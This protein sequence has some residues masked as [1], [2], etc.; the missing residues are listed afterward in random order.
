MNVG[1]H[2]DNVGMVVTAMR[3]AGLRMGLYHSLFEW[4]NP[5][6]IK[7]RDDGG[8][9]TVYV[10]TTLQPMLLDLVNTYQ[11][12]IVWSDGDRDMSD[13]YWGSKEF[14]TWLYNESPVKDEVVVN[15]RWGNG[16]ACHHGG[17]FTCYD[18]YNPGFL[19]KHKWENAMTID[20]KSWGYRKNANIEDM[21]SIQEILFQII[22]TVSCGGNVLL[23]V[24]PTSEGEIIP[25]F[26][27]RLLQVGSWLQ[28]NGDAIYATKPWRAQNDTESNVWYT[29]KNETV[30]A[31]LLDWPLNNTVVLS[32]P[33]PGFNFNVQMLGFQGTYLAWNYFLSNLLIQLPEIPI[34]KLPSPYAWVLQMENVS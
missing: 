10:N 18:R 13:Q 3:K 32:Q 12:D 6:Y 25:L 26:Q 9:T 2:Q 19:L 15:D 1:P 21:L 16:M 14:L 17:F 4:F 28:V 24:G 11:P 30:Y 7:D 27:E 20:S 8:N 5:I 31:I 23:N 33:I 34:S 22:S 29:S